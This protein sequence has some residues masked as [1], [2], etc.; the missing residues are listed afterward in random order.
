MV[1]C[2][3]KTAALI[4]VHIDITVAAVHCIGSGIAAVTVDRE[5]GIA[6]KI[7]LSGLLLQQHAA[8]FICASGH[9]NRD[10]HSVQGER[11][12]GF[13]TGRDGVLV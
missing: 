1:T 8:G 6:R 12:S 2:G 10:R 5:R 9:V 7:Q 4:H 3:C 13:D 11:P